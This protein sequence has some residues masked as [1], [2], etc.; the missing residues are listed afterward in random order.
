MPITIN[1]SGTVTG[2]SVGGLP[3]GIV[4]E[5]TL[6]NL[7]V[8]TGKIANNAVN[9]AKSSLTTGKILQV[10]ELKD[11]GESTFTSTSYA[12]YKSLG[13]VPQ[14]GNKVLVSCVVKYFFIGQASIGYGNQGNF[15]LQILRSNDGF[16]SNSTTLYSSVSDGGG[17]YAAHISARGDDSKTVTG[18]G[19]WADQ[20]V[21]DSPGGDGSKTITYKIQAAKGH[22]DYGNLY[23]GRNE[24]SSIILMEIAS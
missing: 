16:S 18:G 5:D 15:G 10:V 22:S 4:D 9:D 19:S 17:K 1:G 12:D 11:T 8:S 23:L 2:I 21:D 20:F 3:D 14:S 13:I 24:G 7:A 6:A